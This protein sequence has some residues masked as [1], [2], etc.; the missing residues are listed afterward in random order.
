MKKFSVIAITLITLL[1]CK[2]ESSDPLYEE[3]LSFQKVLDLTSKESKQWFINQTPEI[4]SKIW[5]YKLNQVLTF[6]WNESQYNLI[7]ELRKNITEDYFEKSTDSSFELEWLKKAEQYFTVSELFRIIG[8]L[9]AYKIETSYS[10]YKTTGADLPG[11][12]ASPMGECE[13]NT[14]SD[15]CDTPIPIGLSCKL[16]KLCSPTK[17]LG[18]GFLLRY[19]CEGMCSLN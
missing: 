16:T 7:V 13:C 14:N 5:N 11:G 10:S 12:G 1:G 15:W 17:K 8:T 2:K 4:Q 6:N 18:C 9:E 3:N 19:P